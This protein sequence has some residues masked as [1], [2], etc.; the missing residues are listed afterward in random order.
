MF[1]AF[2]IVFASTFMNPMNSKTKRISYLLTPS[3]DFEKFFSR[4]ITF[5][6]GYIISF[7]VALYA[8]E[9]LRVIVCSVRYPDIEIRF[10]DLTGL[11]YPGKDWSFSNYL[12]NKSLFSIAISMYFL[13]QSLFILGS[14][15]WE[16]AT[17]VKTFTAGALIPLLY[18]LICYWTISIF[19][20]NLNNFGNVLQS[21]DSFAENNINEEQSQI[22]AL[23]VIFFFTI[24][25][26]TLAYFRFRESEIIKRL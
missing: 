1:A 3:S 19:Y 6:I 2:G 8:A 17:F 23:S 20:E 12:F 4:L 7:F 15:F 14:T 18:I 10:I 5:T 11:I 21:F 25:N 22:I 24:A 9:I 26:W 16:K 13:F